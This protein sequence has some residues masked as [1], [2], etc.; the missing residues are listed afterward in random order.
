MG[1]GTQTQRY[2]KLVDVPVEER[3]YRVEW[4]MFFTAESPLD[5]A[6][7]AWATLDDATNNNSGASIL[8]VSDEYGEDRFVFDMEHETN[9][10]PSI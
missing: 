9:G 1:A 7:Q 8:F 5:A 4:S 2:F 3:E 6:K 10:E